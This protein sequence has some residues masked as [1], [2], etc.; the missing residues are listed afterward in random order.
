MRVSIVAMIENCSGCVG[1]IG[2]VNM[3]QRHKSPGKLTRL[4]EKERLCQ[5]V[6][7]LYYPLSSDRFATSP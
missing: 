7:A 1:G 3:H 2:A 6:S 4:Q 5:A